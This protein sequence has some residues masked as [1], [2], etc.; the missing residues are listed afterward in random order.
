MRELTATEAN[1][2]AGGIAVTGAIAISLATTFVGAYLYEK[3]GGADGID[4]AISK[5]VETVKDAVDKV[6][7]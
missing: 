6:F 4:N 1:A 3:S 5:V 7:D 2:T